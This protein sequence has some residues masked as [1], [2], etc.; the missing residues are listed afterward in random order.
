MVTSRGRR[1]RFAF[2]TLAVVAVAAVM[3][4]WVL[5]TRSGRVSETNTGAGARDAGTDET[6]AGTAKAGVRKRVAPPAGVPDPVG[7]L[8]LEGQVIDALQQPVAG[9]TVMITTNP[10]RTATTEG[11][12][13]FAFDG[14][15]PRGYRI[16]AIQGSDRADEVSVRL[17]ENSEPII[18]RMHPGMVLAVRVRA[19]GSG[20]PIEGATVT[21]AGWIDRDDVTDHLGQA[22]VG[23]CSS[24][25]NL[26]IVE[27]DGYSPVAMG[28]NLPEDPGGRFEQTVWLHGGARAAGIVLD[29]RGRPVGEAFVGVERA[30]GST[31]TA[32]RSSEDGTWEI[33]SLAA[34]S[35]AVTAIVDGYPPAQQAVNLDGNKP[36]DDI[37][38]RFES[39]ARI[40][41]VVVDASGTPVPHA[42]VEAAIGYDG[43]TRS[44]GADGRFVI[45]GL[46]RGRYEVYAT[47]GDRASALVLID[48]TDA[49]VG[50]LRLAIDDATI[51]GVVV[52]ARGDPVAEADVDAMPL[53]ES[54]SG[55]LDGRSVTDAQG[56]FVVGPLAPGEYELRARWPD[57][58]R[59]NEYLD[60]DL[61]TVAVGARGV[62]LVLETAG[63]LRGR[64]TRGGVPVVRYGIAAG[65]GRRVSSYAVPRVV[66]REDGVFERGGMPPGEYVIVVVGSDFAMKEIAGVLV[67]AGQVTDLGDIEVDEGRVVTGRVV[68][69][70]GDPIAGATV[71]VGMFF[72]PHGGTLGL[73][74][75]PLMGAL[76]HQRSDESDTDG[77]FEIRGVAEGGRPALRILADHPTKGRSREIVLPDDSAPM[78]ITLHAV[79]SIAGVVSGVTA[80]EPLSVD[81]RG[82]DGSAAGRVRTAGGARWQIDGLPAGRYHVRA[83][84]IPDRTS[85]PVEVE[86][87]AG[88]TTEIEIPFL[89]GDI[90][91]AVRT[92]DCYFV[93][94]QDEAETS[95]SLHAL[96][97]VECDK[98]D[99]ISEIGALAP[100]NYNLCVGEACNP[101]TITPRPKRQTVDTRGWR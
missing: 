26:V 74:E 94:L 29:P 52:D 75:D 99:G 88:E 78:E 63:A 66:A 17:R 100:G 71:G 41:G 93:V 97:M 59:D 4:V 1:R 10:I 18:L 47:E 39:G 9:A 64:V 16:A 7:T 21:V 58:P 31:S 92:D 33:P 53:A 8:R 86:V 57:A 87:R 85:H 62:R 28:L 56:R 40:S 36:A 72:A 65:T 48:L 12:G 46:S 27:A 79:G 15:L 38:L 45:D 61:A 30:D 23:A 73:Q 90:T 98:K 68:D 55:G 34:G 70:A 37:V 44:A 91:L 60:R 6:F 96:A 101:V 76:R 25:F 67:E 32:T 69:L 51:Q 35:Y 77:R 19:A 54:P 42:R 13:S 5:S 49:D 2:A 22:E 82:D 83:T 50:D 24:W 81:A 11:D 89:R 80:D 84:I 43:A 20:A 3:L 14:L 95:P